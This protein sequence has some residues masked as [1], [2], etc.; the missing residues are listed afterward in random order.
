MSSSQAAERL[1]QRFGEMYGAR[2]FEAFGPKPND[3]WKSAVQ[4]LRNDQVRKALSKIRNS[5][6]PHPPSL[7]EFLALARNV[8]PVPT[9]TTVVKDMD[10]AAISANWCLLSF[11]IDKGP[12]T[13][14]V[15]TNLVATKN[16][17]VRGYLE[18]V[19]EER[20]PLEDLR[21]VLKNAFGKISEGAA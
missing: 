5:G 13:E 12:F 10:P 15:V 8:S 1:W 2:F 21:S 16:E 9:T 14:G 11:M 6:S 20:E 19:P 17:I 7:P 3:S 4:E 18:S